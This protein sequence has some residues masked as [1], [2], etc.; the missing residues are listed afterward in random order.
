MSD[1]AI[2]IV[3]LFTFF[4]LAGGLSFT[5]YEMRRLHSQ[6]S[7]TDQ[8]RRSSAKRESPIRR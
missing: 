2:C 7:K 6:G 8:W 4:L 5:V 3:G 1:T